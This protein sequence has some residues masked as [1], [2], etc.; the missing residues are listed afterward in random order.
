MNKPNPQDFPPESPHDIEWGGYN[1]E[2]Y[3]AALKAWE[4]RQNITNA[5]SSAL[6]N[7]LQKVYNQ[8]IDNAI[9]VVKEHY[10]VGHSVVGPVM[11]SIIKKLQS[12]KENNG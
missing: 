4:N 7:D 3:E 8:A 11:D 2:K 6:T 12:L 1:H 5:L 10:I 9:T